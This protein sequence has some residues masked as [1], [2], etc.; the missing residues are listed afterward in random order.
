MRAR[1]RE[2]ASCPDPLLGRAGD[3]IA[4]AWGLA[5][6]LVFF[7]VPD[8]FFSLTASRSPLRGLRHVGLV[9]LGSLL[10]GLILHTWATRDAE[11]ARSLVNAVPFVDQSMFA[12]VEADYQRLGSLAPLAGPLS[13]IPYKVYAV[14]GAGHT[15]L[16]PFLLISVPARAERLLITWAQFTVLGLLLRRWTR[17][18]ELW[19]AIGYVAYW[20]V[21]YTLYWSSK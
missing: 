11:A 16:L 21:V 19:S 7:L 13:G 3:A 14:V 8:M 1:A 15:P 2:S 9:I 18:P 10:A 4:I 20:L 12:R 5:E 6:G 17:R